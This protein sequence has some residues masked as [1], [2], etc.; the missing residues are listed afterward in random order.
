ME[1]AAVKIQN[2]S[3]LDTPGTVVLCRLICWSCVIKRTVDG[4]LYII[5]NNNGYRKSKS[6]TLK[7][8]YKA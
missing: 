8:I 3:F 5:L 6:K 2:M 4:I 7:W 1:K